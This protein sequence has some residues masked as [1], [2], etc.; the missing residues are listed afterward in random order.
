MSRLTYGRNIDI[1]P[2]V[3]T[4][5]YVSVFIPQL[6]PW[7]E[8]EKAEIIL[9][10][11]YKIIANIQAKILKKTDKGIIQLFIPFEKEEDRYSCDLP[12]FLEEIGIGTKPAGGLLCDGT[13]WDPGEAAEKAIVCRGGMLSLID[14]PYW[15]MQY[16][17]YFAD[18]N[19][20][21]RLGGR[22]IKI[23]RFS[24]CDKSAW[25]RMESVFRT[26]TA[27][28]VSWN[29][30]EFNILLR[31]VGMWYEA[32]PNKIQVFIADNDE[33][34]DWTDISDLF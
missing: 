32:R 10:D 3:E 12:P 25:G 15:G 33:V 1:S 6:F 30:S 27:D 7:E 22:D 34:F 2:V 9:D 11:E 19:I 29:V 8:E 20:R 23:M 26:M 18:E 17:F 13:R 31:Y 5:D 16:E 14:S 28:K 21:P 4:K 24:Y